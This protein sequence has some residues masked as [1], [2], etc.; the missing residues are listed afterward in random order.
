MQ[1]Q[2]SVSFMVMGILFSVCLVLSNILAVKQFDIWGFPS[3]AGLIIF[4]VSYIIN[5]CIAEVWGFKKARF[6]IWVAF[7][8]NFFAILLFQISIALPP[9][10]YW[11]MQEAYSSVLAQTP[12]IALASLMAFLCGSFLNAYV[13][14]KMKIM[15]RGKHFGL[16][17]IASTI[18][19]ELAD[20]FIFT[21]VGFLFVIP[22]Q[23]VVMI[24]LTET[25]LKTLFEIIIL[26]LTTKVVRQVKE[27][28][29]VD[30]YDDN[31]SYNVLRIKEI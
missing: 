5:D 30:V 9:A 11:Q 23:A 2:L 22:L 13:M 27:R 31:I 8:V 21:T 17:A 20:T 6:I 14:S 10:D 24:I 18:V 3:T 19:G 28:E 16:R 15:H 29:G 12:R 4:P 26:P 1:K 7:A 25:V